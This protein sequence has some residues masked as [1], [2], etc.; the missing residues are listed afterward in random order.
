MIKQRTRGHTDADTRTRTHG[1]RHTDADTWRANLEQPHE[2]L[3][4][5]GYWLQVRALGAPPG[6]GGQGDHAQQSPLQAGET[7]EPRRIR[8]PQ[9]LEQAESQLALERPCKRQ[10]YPSKGGDRQRESETQAERE[11]ETQAERERERESKRKA[12]T[13][14]SMVTV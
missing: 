5:E 10:A 11:R 7:V 13:F 4:A 1:R 3:G 2:V 6:Q 8:H 12:G 9:A 14:P